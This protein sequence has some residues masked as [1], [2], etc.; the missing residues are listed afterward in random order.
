MA[1]YFRDLKHA[2]R[3]LMRSPGF[4]LVVILTLALGIGGN[5]AILAAARIIFLAPLPFPHSD[6]LVR[7]RATT[8]GPAG[9]QN[10]FNLRG[11]EIQVLEDQAATSPF[12]AL[13][14]LDVENRTLLG[15]EAPERISVSGYHGDWDSVLGIRP[16]IGRWFSQEEERRGDQSGVA[17]ISSSL[18]SRHF[19]NDRT[20]VGQ[21]I[22]LDNRAHGIIGVMPE[23]FHFPYTAEVWTP[24]TIASSGV[25]DYAVFGR[26][27]EGASIAAA[28]QS[29]TVV[30]KALV[31]QFPNL[32]TVGVGLKLWPLRE[33]F[34]EGQ[35]RAAVALAAVGGFFLLLASLNVASLLLARSV[36]RRRELQVRAALGASRWQLI[37][38][39]LSETLILSLAGAVLGI[40]FAGLVSPHLSVLIPAVLTR[41]LNMTPPSVG[42]FSLGAALAL[43]L[44][45]SVVAGF[46]PATTS[47][48]ISPDGIGRE[49]TRTTGSRRERRCPAR[50]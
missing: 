14:A 46:L 19:G 36:T 6:K 17:V 41:E 22:F 37:R 39:S 4:S 38:L 33:S 27:R 13:V 21:S 2:A 42:W 9:D 7:M 20:V 35:Q 18:W 3:S 16:L 43:S 15:A 31:Q 24:T 25:N 8:T 23:G 45:I 30:T 1:E 11:S 32:Y 44:V 28:S 47:S 5:T 26:L 48:S 50:S 49:S 40:A 10:A 12:S 29:L 34:L